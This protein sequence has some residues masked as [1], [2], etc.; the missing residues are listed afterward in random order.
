[1]ILIFL[2]YNVRKFVELPFHSFKTDK[3]QFE[4]SLYLTDLAWLLNKINATGCV[5][6][7][8]DIY[9]LSAHHVDGATLAVHLEFLK[10]FLEI[11]SKPLNYDAQ[12]LNSLLLAYIKC[13]NENDNTIIQG[14]KKAIEDSKDLRIEKIENEHVET[15][16]VSDEENEKGYDF[17]MNCANNNF[18]ISLSTDREEIC[19]WNVTKYVLVANQHL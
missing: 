13:S 4:T 18:V 5:Q 3:L 14:W 12:Q 15:A 11:H 10:R 9:L 17:I 1:M 8:N 6:L 19:V 16:E 7:L 2:S